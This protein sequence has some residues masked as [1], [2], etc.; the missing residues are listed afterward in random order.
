MLN[1]LRKH[2]RIFFIV[3]TAAIIVSFCFFG[4][5]STMG[6]REE[7]P[8]SELVC[9]VSG[10][11]IMQQELSALCR[12]IEH[13]PFDPIDQERSEMPNFLND[14][15]IEKDFLGN[16][17]GV[18]LAK[19]YFEKFQPDLD[20]R[21]QKIRQFRSYVHPRTNQISAEGAWSRFSPSLS[22]HLRALK[23]TSDPA[24]TETLALMANLYLD[25]A[26]MSPSILKQIL[27]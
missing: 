7:V 24:S 18:I 4:T 8:D 23:E 3:I 13:S 25:Q 12:L 21:M 2:Q 9:G 1:F 20:K 26:R 27:N 16:G 17:L 22:E 5:Y 19:Q 11:P 14:G 10:A 6:N 15:V